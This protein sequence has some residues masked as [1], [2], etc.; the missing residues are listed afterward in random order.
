[1]LIMEVVLAVVLVL[2]FLEGLSV[3]IYIYATL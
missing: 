3:Y 2:G 1:M